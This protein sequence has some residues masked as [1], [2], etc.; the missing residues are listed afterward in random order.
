MERARMAELLGEVED[1][2]EK[3]ADDND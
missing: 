2:E 1:E 3:I